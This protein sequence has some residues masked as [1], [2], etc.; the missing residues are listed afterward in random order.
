[1]QK[2]DKP[3]G[4]IRMMYEAQPLA[5]IAEQAG[6]YGSD[7]IGNILDMQPHDLHQR[8]PFFVGSRDLVDLAEDYIKKHDQEWVQSYMPYRTKV[9]APASIEQKPV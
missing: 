1:L 7:G 9:Y 8:T 5:F 6:G 3:F 2:A 4:K